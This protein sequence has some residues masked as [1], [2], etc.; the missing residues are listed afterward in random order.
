[1]EQKS[2]TIT[3]QRRCLLSQNGDTRKTEKR[4]CTYGSNCLQD[5]NVR[6]V[7]VVSV[8]TCKI[9]YKAKNF[10]SLQWMHNFFLLRPVPTQIGLHD[11]ERCLMVFLIRN[12]LNLQHFIRVYVF[13]QLQ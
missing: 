10:F 5:L 8:A 6:N 13:K 11:H 1:M 12:I 3:S 9:V 4:N 7:P 2:F